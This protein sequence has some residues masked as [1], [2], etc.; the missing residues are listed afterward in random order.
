MNEKTADRSGRSPAAGTRAYEDLRRRHL[1][2]ARARE[3]YRESA[4]LIDLVNK[5]SRKSLWALIEIYRRLLRRI[6]ESNFDVMERRI[7]LS[8]AEKLAILAQ[9]IFVNR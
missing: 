9:S 3:Y 4:P 6:E 1:E 5:R 2:A 7:R 8:T